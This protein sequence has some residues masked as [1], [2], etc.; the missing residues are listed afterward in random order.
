LILG[1]ETNDHDD[2][3]DDDDEF[4]IRPLKINKKKD[5]RKETKNFS[6][7]QEINYLFKSKKYKK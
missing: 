4:L 6:E 3:D 7:E 5:L 1:K 2:N